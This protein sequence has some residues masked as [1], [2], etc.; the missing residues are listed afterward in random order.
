MTHAS[1]FSGIGGPE[2]AAEML[3]WD[4]V[5]HCEVDS[6]CNKILNYWFPNAKSYKDVRQTDFREW[7]GK[8]DVLSGGFPCQPFSTAG[9]RKGA[10][11]DRYL[12]PEML[13]CIDEIRPTWV[14]GENVVGIT[15]M[16]QSESV[17]NLEN[18]ASLFQEDNRLYKHRCV[19]EFTIEKICTDIESLQYDVQPIVIP[20]CAVGAP[21]RR[22]RVFILG[23]QRDVADTDSMGRS[24][25]RCKT[26]KG[27]TDGVQAQVFG[28]TE[29]QS[30]GK[31]ATD[32]IGEGLQGRH[33][34]DTQG[35][36]YSSVCTG[37]PCET[38]GER[39]RTFP[40]VSPVHR[41]NDGIP[42]DVDRL[43]IP[44]GKWRTESIKAY[45]NAIVPQVIF[46][47]YRCIDIVENE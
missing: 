19:G 7:R 29:G 32:T 13:R 27:W 14:V 42:F 30:G 6:F 3:G 40:S 28:K 18:Q 16:V 45:G 24:R 21:H 5:F 15:S 2:I 31:T 1:V 41:G 25:R 36:G 23:R 20:A 26:D 8:I 33:D 34:C 10:N 11:D 12:W 46:D 4:N 35:H 9:K 43:T 47:I 44:F 17:I 38:H 37:Q 22:D 39:W